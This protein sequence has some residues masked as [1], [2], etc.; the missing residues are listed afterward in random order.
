[1]KNL[2]LSKPSLVN[3]VRGSLWMGGAPPVGP[4]VSRHFDALALCAVEYQ[5]PNA[6]PGVETLAVPLNDDGS[7]MTR[8]EAKAAV[9]AAG[10]VISW[11]SSG[12]S[13]LVTCYMGLNRSGLVTAI[14]LCKGPDPLR[15]NQAISLIREARGPGALRND[16]FI[17]FLKEYCGR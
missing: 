4:T 11:L 9:A 16:Y 3:Q 2:L 8:Q 14:A 7:P 10:Q 13:V 1:M 15:V 12:K 5:V 6:F 17:Q